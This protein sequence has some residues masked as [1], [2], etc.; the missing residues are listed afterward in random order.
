V[1][2][3]LCSHPDRYTS[4]VFPFTFSTFLLVSTPPP[5]PTSFLFFPSFQ[6]QH[7]TPT[8]AS[9]DETRFRL[10]S[11]HFFSFLPCALARHAFFR[12]RPVRAGPWE[13]ILEVYLSAIK[14]CF[15]LKRQSH[16]L[17]LSPF[18]FHS[19]CVVILFGL[20]FS[21]KIQARFCLAFSNTV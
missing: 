6:A 19:P 5:Q 17:P 13:D 21:L 15:F 8:W 3:L 20:S 9:S 10:P 7:L 11:L 2:S 4:A 1:P 14:F 16:R 18:S 12:P